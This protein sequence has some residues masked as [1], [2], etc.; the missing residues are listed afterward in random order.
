MFTNLPPGLKK[1]K[2]YT[3]TLGIHGSLLYNSGT[4]LYPPSLP[5]RIE[6]SR[7][8]ADGSHA[9][10][11]AVRETSRTGRRPQAP[12]RGGRGSGTPGG[13]GRGGGSFSYEPWAGWVLENYG[14]YTTILAAFTRKAANM[15]LKVGR[16]IYRMPFFITRVIG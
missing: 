16:D 2:T 7:T 11:G 15:S 10:D 9:G 12:T 1:E 3:G 4:N 14:L 8:N 6:P 13:G 5:Q